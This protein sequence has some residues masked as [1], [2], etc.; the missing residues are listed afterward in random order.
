MNVL[1]ILGALAA[2]VLLGWLLCSRR[3]E[4]EL[5]RALTDAAGLRATLHNEYAAAERREALLV[6]ADA[7]AR[8]SVGAEAAEALEQVR[9][10]LAELQRGRA[11]SDAVLREQARA[12]ADAS[13]LVQTETSQLVTALRAPQ[14]RGRWGEMQLERVVEAAGMTAQVDYDTQVSATADGATQRP[15][16]IVRLTGG[17]QVVVDSKLAC[18]AYLDAMQARDEP[19]RNARMKA[20]AR[21]LRQHVDDLAAKSYWQRF[22]PTPEFVVCF[23]PADAFLDAALREDGAL[24]EHAFAR[25]VVLATPS[26]LVAL[27]RTIA[28][29]WRQEALAAN[30]EAVHELG[31]ELYRRISTLAGHVERLGR[32]LGG[33]V[34]AYNDAV[35]SLERRVVS[36]A[37][38]MSEL[39]VVA[40]DPAPPSPQPLVDA[41]PRPLTAAE[42]VEP[43]L[44]EPRL[45]ALHT[46]SERDGATGAS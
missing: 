17:K 44:V 13:R 4:R 12:M 34:T 16:L 14:V 33:A 46:A 6:R 38:R 28:Y 42:L 41:V 20:H 11:G 1:I 23:V 3:T 31:R 25:N 45:V 7:E 24:L 27:L 26:T 43:R 2:G 15:D 29:T 35:G 39:G 5:R 37:R 9:L 36:T 21:Q 18:S 32:S 8:E 30:A 40:A 10:Q 19:T 22:T